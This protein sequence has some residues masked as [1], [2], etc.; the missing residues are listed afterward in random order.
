MVRKGQPLAIIDQRPLKMALLQAQGALTRDQAQLTNAK[1][2]LERYRTLLAQDSVARQDVDTQAALV[3]QLEGVVMTDQAAVGVAQINL[4][5]SR[6]TAPVSGRVGLRVVDVG[7]LISANSPTGI[8]V[9][10]QVTPIDVEFTV[11]Q[12]EVPRLQAQSSHGILTVTALDRTKTETL[13][14][15]VFST[16][17]NQVDTT[18]GTVKAKARFPNAR[19]TLFPN[20]FVNVRLDLQTLAGVVVVPVTA[21]RTGPDGDFVWKLESD[22]TV[23]HVK[24]RRGPGTPTTVAILSGLSPGERVIT[25]GGDRLTEGSSVQLPGDKSGVGGGLQACQADM[26]RFCD[27]KQGR[28]RF[29]CLR[30]NA[31]RLSAPCKDALARRRRP[32]GGSGGA[33]GGGG[34]GGGS[35]AIQAPALP[36]RPSQAGAHLPRGPQGQDGAAPRPTDQG[37]PLAGAGGGPPPSPEMMAARQAMRQACAADA[38]KLC[39]GKEGRDMFM[40]LR[41]NADQASGACKAAMAKAPRR[42]PDGGGAPAGGG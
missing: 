23:S 36:A 33:S 10:T 18:T 30:E 21:V 11:P 9:I 20:Q 25:D 12:D 22:R 7:N 3:K 19:G 24:V 16:L 41:G 13:D 38:R 34:Q 32:G 40:C 17:D 6:V 26:K 14:R 37:P 4:G 27:G 8:A 35:D 42:G 1:L 31:D 15:G 28:E 39:P 29:M 2:L 5:Y